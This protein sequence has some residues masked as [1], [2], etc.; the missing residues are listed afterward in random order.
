M[1]LALASWLTLFYYLEGNCF[2]ILCWL[3]LYN[4][5]SAMKKKV[6]VSAAQS[7][8]DSLPPYGL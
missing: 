3:L 5:E 7:Y 8:P 2:T 6:K 1:S 4:C